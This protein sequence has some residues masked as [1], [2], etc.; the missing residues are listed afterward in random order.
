MGRTAAF[1]SN[2]VMVLDTKKVKAF[3][4]TR[5]RY[6][7]A[8]PFESI[9]N[10]EQDAQA[11]AIKIREETHKIF[12]WLP[13][14]AGKSVLDLGAGVGQWAFRF[15]EHGA[16]RVT[17]VEFSSALVDIGRQE[18]RAR[19][20][21]GIEFVIS[22]AEEYLSNRLFDVVFVSGL[23]V[24]LND[25]Q[26]EALLKNMRHYTSQD[27]MILLRDGTGR[28]QRFEIN[29]RFSEQLNAGYSATYRTA[30]QYRELFARHGFELTNDDDMFPD[31][32][33][34]NKYPETR[35]RIYQ[36]RKRHG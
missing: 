6:Y 19:G 35:L 32:H 28:V 26:A 10:L 17:A 29:D 24:Y 9:V 16:A 30:S 3:W 23:M 34:L 31:G 21:D 4:D 36:F 25:D 12:A 22:A 33:V 20:V 27:T 2:G 18:A 14:L 15:M 11:L 8:L 13:G 5:S 1:N 7:Q